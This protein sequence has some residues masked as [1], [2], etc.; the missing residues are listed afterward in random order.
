MGRDIH[1]YGN[2]QE[3]KVA[4]GMG[5]EQYNIERTILKA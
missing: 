5:Q 4:G 2:R 1:L 3:M